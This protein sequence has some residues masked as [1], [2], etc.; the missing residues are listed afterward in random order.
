MRGGRRKRGLFDECGWL[1]RIFDG[2]NGQTGVDEAVGEWMVKVW[3]KGGG[4]AFSWE[5]LY[6]LIRAAPPAVVPYLCG[7]FSVR[8]L[9][10]P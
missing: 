6:H 2:E 9:M 7:G 4:V 3:T 5:L 10:L 1:I 8:T